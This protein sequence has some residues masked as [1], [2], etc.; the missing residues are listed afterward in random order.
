VLLIGLALADC[1]DVVL[2]VDEQC[3]DGNAL[4]DDGCF[5]CRIERG[6][7]CE[8]APL[9][10]GVEVVEFPDPLRTDD[11][12]WEVDGL[13]ARH[14]TNGP[15]TVLETGLSADHV[16]F[17]LT[18]QTVEDEDFIGWTVGDL[19]AGWQLYDWKQTD[20]DSDCGTALRGLARSTVSSAVDGEDLWCHSGPVAEQ[21]AGATLSVAGWADRNT[22]RIE[23]LDGTVWV[24]GVEQFTGQSLSGPLGFYNFSQANVEYQVLEPWEQTVCEAAP[25]TGTWS[26]GWCA[27]TEPRFAGLLLLVGMWRR[28]EPGEAP[29]EQV[30]WRRR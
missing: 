2:D 27:G 28:R 3:D 14:A 23:L 16:V 8:Q 21:E 7:T 24:D 1:G 5:E 11:V 15:P 29:A 17:D 10:L 6:W 19:V 13:W 9:S 18:V 25:D 12:W 30:G 26:G 20:E 4:P 22:H